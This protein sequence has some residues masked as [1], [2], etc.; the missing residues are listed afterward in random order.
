MIGSQTISDRVLLPAT[1]ERWAIA[2]SA[3]L[4]RALSILLEDAP[5][6]VACRT[7]SALETI[8]GWT[9]E[10]EWAE[11]MWS[12]SR[13]TGD[14]FPIE[15]TFSSTDEGIT[16]DGEVAGP[17]VPDGQRL[18]RAFDTLKRLGQP[19]PPTEIVDLLTRIQASGALSYGAWIGA[20]HHVDGDRYKVYAEVPRS[21]WYK[22]RDE[23]GYLLGP[24]PL[25][26]NCGIQLRLI[27][28]DPHKRRT[29]LYFR[30]EQ[31][32]T[33]ELARLLNRA[34]LGGRL[35]ELLTL[36]ED[37][38]GCSIGDTIPGANLGF[39]YSFGSDIKPIA[40]SL[41]AVARSLFGGDESIRKRLLALAMKRGW[42]V[43]T[44]EKLSAPIASRTGRRTRHC[45]LSFVVPP[46]G[47]LSIRVGMSPP[48]GARDLD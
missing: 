34:G 33:L 14:G 3:R 32:E 42:D 9:L 13:L 22:T 2:E 39:S 19:Q 44:Y 47:D 12:F 31:L 41:F 36:L 23:F 17:E 45:V 7:R 21:R 18:L 35:E 26:N 11:V 38:Y 28:Y 37:C 8:F 5:A 40:F 48:D 27:G 29:E 25:L 16:Y 15:F 24:E 1:A 43:N 4:E 46:E 20:R 10:S 30:V 6:A